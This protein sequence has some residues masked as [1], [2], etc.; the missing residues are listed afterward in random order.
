MNDAVRKLLV[1]GGGL[2]GLA[3]ALA[4]AR[5]GIDVELIEARGDWHTAPA[6]VNVPPNMLR[7]LARLGVAEDCVRVGFPY[8]GASFLDLRGRELYQLPTER[9]A[10]ERLPC[11]LGIAQPAL[12]GV[13][14]AAARRAGA[15]LHTG[16]GCESIEH[17][18]GRVTFTDGRS[19]T[20]D[21]LVGADGAES[22]LRSQL[23]G[24]QF[25]PQPTTQAWWRAIVSRPRELDRPTM[26]IGLERGRAGAIPVSSR[27]ACMVLLQG[28]SD[29]RLPPPGRRAA[30][31]R[32]RLA[33]CEGMVAAMRD[34]IGLDGDT[35]QIQWVRSGLLPMPWHRGR[36]LL[37]GD[38]VHT[39]TP[40]LGQSGAQ[41]LEDAVV[42]G[43]LLAGSMPL[44]VLL[45]RFM[46][47]RFER[48]R[49]TQQ[50]SQ[51]IAHW[52]LRPGPETDIPRVAEQ[53]ALAVAQPA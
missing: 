41:S 39:I 1:I 29:D 7:D 10:G 49:I 28:E 45:D 51:Q 18:A 15:V 30:A 32:E 24:S 14:V 42:L 52:E 48:A 22:R 33:R 3:S 21:L 31:M 47:R 26:V 8:Q 23:F 6:H 37:I 4:A 46:A 53:Q 40:H 43:D 2:A 11:A 34:Q 13:L 5:A 50:C 17:E 16:I 38:A 20:Y 36:V 27:Q 25:S 44:D 9:L 12:I 19:A 35:V